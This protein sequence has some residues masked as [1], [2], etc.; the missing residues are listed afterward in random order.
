M[1][2]VAASLSR[3]PGVA[4]ELIEVMA[5]TDG[6]VTL[7]GRAPSH[8]AREAARRAAMRVRVVTTVADEVAVT[9]AW[10]HPAVGGM[11]ADV[12]RPDLLSTARW[13]AGGWTPSCRT[14]C[15]SGHTSGEGT[16]QLTK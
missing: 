7:S 10:G 9:Q 1:G 12:D 5:R 4:A 14:N 6:A 15:R 11:V 3:A 13:K 8:P 16:P 2:A